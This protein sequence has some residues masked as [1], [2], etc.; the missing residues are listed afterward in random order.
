M[1]LKQK[2]IAMNVAMLLFIL[3]FTFASLYT[4]SPCFQYYM[5]TLESCKF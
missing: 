2:K 1:T 5:E 4:L 3:G